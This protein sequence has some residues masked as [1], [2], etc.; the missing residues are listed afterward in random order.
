MTKVDS[1]S[2]LLLRQIAEETKEK[3]KLYDRIKQLV[4]ENNKLKEQLGIKDK[5]DG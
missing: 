2:Q 4:E 3:Y 1:T 5:K